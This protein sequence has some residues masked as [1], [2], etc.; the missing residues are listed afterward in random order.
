VSY[1]YFSVYQKDIQDIATLFHQEYYPDTLDAAAIV[2]TQS[3]YAEEMTDK[4]YRQRKKFQYNIS[5]EN[6]LNTAV[7]SLLG[8]LNNHLISIGE[9]MLTVSGVG[10]VLNSRV[11]Y[12]ANEFL[13]FGIIEAS[14]ISAFLNRNSKYIEIYDFYE[15]ELLKLVDKGKL[16]SDLLQKLKLLNQF[17]RTLNNVQQNIIH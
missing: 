2:F 14:L 5:D 4:S 7:Q 13:R 16:Y 15:S 6:N 9:S 17:L 3:D 10:E 11:E 8:V 1:F 12:W